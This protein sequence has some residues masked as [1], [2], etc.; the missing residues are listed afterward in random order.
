[1]NQILLCAQV[2]LGRLNRCVTQEQLDLLKFA[3]SGAAQLGARAA[4]MPHAA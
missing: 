3:A 4:I 2:P 1:M